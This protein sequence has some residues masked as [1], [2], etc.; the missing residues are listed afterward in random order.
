LEA[1]SRATNPCAAATSEENPYSNYQGI[2][3]A[4]QGIFLKKQGNLAAFERGV[5]V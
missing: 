4:D 2:Y 1:F 3:S 5:Q